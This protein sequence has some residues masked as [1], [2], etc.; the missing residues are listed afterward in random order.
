MKASFW[1]FAYRRYQSRTLSRLTDFAALTWALFFVLF[2]GAALLT[3]WRPSASEAML[4]VVLIGTPL[5]LGF[6]HR[7]IRLEAAKGPD[8]LYRKMVATS[9]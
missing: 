9:Q 4:G 3:G 2:Y 5:T 6:V 8:A 1:R 7:R